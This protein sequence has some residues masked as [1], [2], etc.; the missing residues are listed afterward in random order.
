MIMKKCIFFVVGAVA[1]VL[2]SCGG[3]GAES[4]APEFPTAVVAGSD[5]RI[6]TSFPASIKG[7]QD[8]EIRPKISGFITAINVSEGQYV[9]KGQT[10][11]VIDNETY[12]AAAN[13]AKAAVAA[14]EA[15]LQT[16]QLTYEN[17]QKL[18]D[19]NV[20][21][22]YELQSSQ[23]SYTA[24]QAAL[25]QAKATYAEAK[26]NLDFCF[27]ASPADGVVG[28]LPYKVGALV[29]SSSAEPLTTVSDINGVQVYFSMS[30]KDLLDMT[31]A[32]GA[33]SDAVKA[34]PRVQ[35]QLADGSLYADKGTVAAI[36]GVIDATTG[37]VLV[38]ADFP[39]AAHLL[40]SGGAGTILVPHTVRDAIVIPQTAVSEI[41]NKQFVFVVGDDNTVKHTEITVDPQDDGL[42][43]IVTSG[44]AMGERYVTSGITSLTDGQAITPLTVQEYA[45]KINA[46]QAMGADQ[47]DLSKL[48]KD[49]GQ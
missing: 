31:K 48:K 44:L 40:K 34:F 26:Q 5:T 39:N 32:A 43:Y 49:L 22:A 33:L 47:G 2:T 11:F 3:G 29:S 42:N 46:V 17:A 12:Q 25:A 24:A 8:V 6:D 15:Q 21:G 35:L 10:L 36:S 41:Q 1:M 28:E 19:N 20:V 38:R 45:E 4:A 23:N 27:V 13:Q 18:F 14:A 9:S 16:A 7:V 30:E 37:A